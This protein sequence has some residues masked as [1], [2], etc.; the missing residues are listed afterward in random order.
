MTLL[1][2]RAKKSLWTGDTSDPKKRAGAIESFERRA[3]DTDGVSVFEVTT[4][5]EKCLVVAAIA[6]D[7]GKDDPV[8]LLEIPRELAEEYG[9]IVPTEGTTAVPAANGLHRSL[10]WS[11]ERLRTFAERLFDAGLAAKRHS[12]PAV[13]EAVAKLDP[14]KDVE[15]DAATVRGFVLAAKERASG[16]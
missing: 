8:D 12:S 6:C 13:R 16:R 11:A 1:L 15:A 5:A 3:E 14:E 2:R 4:E 9:P 7:R 10:D